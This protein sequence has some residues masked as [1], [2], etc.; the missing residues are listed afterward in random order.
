MTNL[1]GSV[2]GTHHCKL[3]FFSDTDLLTLIRVAKTENVSLLNYERCG[4]GGKGARRSKTHRE[5]L[6]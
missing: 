1:A 3:A 4:R 5:F 2:S 6:P